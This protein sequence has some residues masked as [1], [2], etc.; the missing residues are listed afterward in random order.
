MKKWCVSLLLLAIV[1][2]PFTFAQTDSSAKAIAITNAT[3]IEVTGKPLERNMTVVIQGQYIAAVGKTAKVQVAKDA[4]VIDAAGKFLIPGLWDMH[5]HNAT[6]FSE[7]YIANGVTGV[8]DMFAQ[9]SA[10]KSAREAIA[11]G[12]QVGPRMVASSRI[13]DGPQPVWPNSIAVKNAEEG[14]QAVSTARAE[15][16]EFIKVYSLLSRES[17]FAIAEEAKKQG[18]PFV[19]HVP[20]VVTAAEASEAGQ[21]SMEH[22][23]GILLGCSKREEE[24]RKTLA[25]TPA[26]ERRQVQGKIFSEIDYDE[27]KAGALFARFVKNHTW[28]CPTL[29]VLRSL[30]SL[31]IESFINDPRLKYLQ[32]GFKNF[33]NHKN[34]FRLKTMTSEDWAYQRKIF[35]K[36]KQVVGRMRRAGVEF[37]AGTDVMN[38]FCFPGFSLHDELALLVESG[39]TPLEALQAATINPARFLGMENR[40]G[41]IEA[42]KLADLVLLDANPLEDI[43]NTTKIYMVV[44]NG[45]LFTQAMLKQMLDKAES[46][47]R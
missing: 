7:L 22:L 19:G 11:A 25:A 1:L 27:A 35:E 45:R 31:D 26:A 4:Q 15:G 23:N 9:M 30:A 40:L 44:A 8:R 20:N 2:V 14:R 34:D 32:P 3:I 6:G 12:Q 21:K 29:T 46:A 41:T 42:G 33:W 5:V 47:N 13:V 28:Q 37:I 43:R 10:I 39:F 36:N 17:Y 16:A 24:I 38:P 18:I